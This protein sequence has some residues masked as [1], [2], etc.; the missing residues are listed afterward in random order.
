MPRFATFDGTM[1]HY[2]DDGPTGIKTQAAL[3][4]YRSA[5]STGGAF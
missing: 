3:S 1:L 5:H 4:H 2:D